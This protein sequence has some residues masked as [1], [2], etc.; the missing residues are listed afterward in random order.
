MVTD[1]L[2]KNAPKREWN[3]QLICLLLLSYWKSHQRIGGSLICKIYFLQDASLLDKEIGVTIEAEDFLEDLQSPDEYEQSVMKQILIYCRNLTLESKYREIRTFLSNPNHAVM[4]F[5][6]IYEFKSKLNDVNLAQLF[7]ACFEEIDNVDQY[8]RCPNCGWTLVWKNGHWRCNK[9]SVCH[10][11]KDFND[12]EYFPNTDQKLFRLTP[13]IQKYILL[14]GMSE[15]RIAEKLRRK[16]LMVTLYPNINQY[17]ISV[18]ANDKSIFMDV[19]DYRSPFQIAQYINRNLNN[20]EDE[21]WYVIP[22]YRV[23]N[24][25]GYIETVKTLLQNNGNPLLNV[26]SEKQAIKEAE[27]RLR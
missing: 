8:R 2:L 7:H 18:E 15:I 17:D 5:Y 25:P 26:V 21:V 16:V 24:S 20:L 19:K 14:P 9:E 6:K 4:P 22:D 13:G 3:H 27:K 12:L 11:L 1:Y 23:K 10:S